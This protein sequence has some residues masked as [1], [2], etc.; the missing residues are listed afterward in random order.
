MRDVYEEHQRIRAAFPRIEGAGDDILSLADYIDRRPERFYSRAA[1]DAMTAMLD[2][3]R[4]EHPDLLARFFRTHHEALK[5]AF[6]SM[7][8]VNRI[9]MQDRTL[10]DL[11]DEV[12]QLFILDTIVHPAYLRLTESVL[13]TTILPAAQVER[14]RR[15]ADEINIDLQL[16]VKELADGPLASFFEPFPRT[17]RNAIAHGGLVFHD[18][19]VEYRDK[20]ETVKYGI[21]SAFELFDR[22]VDVCNGFL[23]AY[24][25][26]FVAAASF[27]ADENLAV[28]LPPL[29]RELQAQVEWPEWRILGALETMYADE[30]PGLRL[31]IDTSFPQDIDVYKA[32]AMTAA[33]AERLAPVFDTYEIHLNASEMPK[34]V[35]VFKAEVLRSLRAAGVVTPMEIAGAFDSILVF[36]KITEEKSDSV[37]D[38]L[39]PGSPFIRRTRLVRKE[40]YLQLDATMILEMAD[41]EAAR[42]YVR[43]NAHDLV[44]VAIDFARD[45][46]PDNHLRSLPIG[47]LDLTFLLLDARQRD[48]HG[49]GSNVLGRIIERRLG[50]I[51]VPPLYKS[52]VERLGTM[53]IEWNTVPF[54]DD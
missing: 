39:T 3:I 10:G 35:G 19:G 28:P 50:R 21:R 17:V 26:F 34:G 25:L 45:R 48:I 54:G 16:R 24:R 12:R 37:A 8:D 46:L 33:T 20:K 7:D 52:E 2:A 36:P 40:D 31:F 42:M 14:C 15:A 13:G 9:A 30:R 44:K 51:E 11:G 53:R 43:A 6:R 23:L 41:R 27:F 49:I 18:N 32:T 1:A 4:H 22:A 47:F 5:T 38:A 29:I